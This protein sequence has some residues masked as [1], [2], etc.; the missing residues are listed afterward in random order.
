MGRSR[1]RRLGSV[2]HFTDLGLAIIKNPPKLP[3]IGAAV[4]TENL[5]HVGMVSD[6]FGPVKSPYV[7]IKV[8]DEYKEMLNKNTIL[9]ALDEPKK[10]RQRIGSKKRNQKMKRKYSK[11]KYKK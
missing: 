4:V 8:K 2:L 11:P 9:Y 7:S 5:L 3:K 10:T 1:L 6:I